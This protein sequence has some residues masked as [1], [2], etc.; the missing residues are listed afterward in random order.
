MPL[1]IC[2]KNKIQKDITNEQS[3]TKKCLVLS[4]LGMLSVLT[5]VYI[6]LTNAIVTKGYTIKNLEEES[7]KLREAYKRLELQAAELQDINRLNKAE[8]MGLVAVDKIEYLG[9]VTVNGVAVR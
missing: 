1:Y 2:S 3:K 6:I 9:V 7:T 5:V 4:L 8:A